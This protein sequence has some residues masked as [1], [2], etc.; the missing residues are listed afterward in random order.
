MQNKKNISTANEPDFFGKVYE[1]VGRIPFGSV[2]T[3]GLIAEALGAKSSARMV[4]WALNA[5]VGRLDLPCHRVINR[6]G[7]LSGRMHFAT[8]T[9]MRELLESEGIEFIGDAVDLKKHL[10][11]PH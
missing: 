9:L 6:N 1:I 10:W 4:G 11:K 5:V 2:T 8:P 7:E 3:Y